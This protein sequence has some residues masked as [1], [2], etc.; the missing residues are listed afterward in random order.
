M[1]KAH[2]VGVL[3]PTKVWAGINPKERSLDLR[4]KNRV[5]VLGK[6]AV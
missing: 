4:I 5:A 3:R 2:G 6:G 1:A